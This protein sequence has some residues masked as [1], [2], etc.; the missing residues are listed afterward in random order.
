MTMPPNLQVSLVNYIFFP[1]E[2]CVRDHFQL[3]ATTAHAFLRFYVIYF[4]LRMHFVDF[5]RHCFGSFLADWRR[6]WWDQRWQACLECH[7]APFDRDRC[8]NSLMYWWMSICSRSMVRRSKLLERITNG[9]G[10][11]GVYK[12]GVEK[13]WNKHST[14]V[15]FYKIIFIM[16]FWAE[17][18]KPKIC[19][20]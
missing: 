19:G 16:F 5:S 1:F 15:V 12:H 7:C 8:M 9:C 3:Y 13:I 2:K 18:S 10:V 14:V 20:F 4:L 17:I 11:L 6:S